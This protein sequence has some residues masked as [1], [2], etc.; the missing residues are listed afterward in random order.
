VN[1]RRLYRSADDRLVAGVAGGLAAYLDVD[2]VIVRIIWFL[3]M[4]L[5]GTA[6][7]W[8]YLIMIVVVPL[9]PTEWPPQSPWA[10]G[11]APIGSEA[12]PT[13]PTADTIPGSAAGVAGSSPSATS[14]AGPSA[15]FGGTPPPA[16]GGWWGGDWRAQTRQ[17]LWQQRAERDEYRASGGPGLVFGLMLVLIGGLLA[18]HQFDPSFDLNRVWPIAIIFFGGILV[19]SAFGF[20][21]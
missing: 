14:A 9:E 2:P 12:A 11:G 4:L 6:T 16:A 7:L 17:A 21:K 1:P 10:P 13:P 8:I 15:A 18:W 20:R 5:T 19:V 3:S